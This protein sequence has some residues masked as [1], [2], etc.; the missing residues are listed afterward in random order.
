L[1][2]PRA[3]RGRGLDL[4]FV[5]LADD[6]D[7]NIVYR[8]AAGTEEHYAESHTADVVRNVGHDLVGLPLG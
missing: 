2:K 4:L 8:G 3:V 6:L 7:L 1:V 5:N